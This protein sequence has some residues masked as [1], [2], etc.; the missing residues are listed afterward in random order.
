MNDLKRLIS[1]LKAEG[2]VTSQEAFEVWKN[3][4][5]TISRAGYLTYGT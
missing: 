5:F 4:S 1:K 3:S 2:D